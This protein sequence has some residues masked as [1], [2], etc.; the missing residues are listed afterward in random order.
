MAPKLIN[1]YT[2]NSSNGQRASIML[3]ESGLDYAA[4]KVDMSLGA[5]KLP[6]ALQ[7]LPSSDVPAL[8][9]ETGPGEAVILF[10]SA[11]IAL[12]V[13][14]K[15]GKFVPKDSA[16]RARVIQWLVQSVADV[17][18]ASY[19]LYY[20]VGNMTFDMGHQAAGFFEQRLLRY[21]DT[22]D[23][24]LSETPYLGGELSVADFALYPAVAF[25]RRIIQKAG[26]LKHL[27]RWAE[28]LGER[29]G[30]R[31][32]MAIAGFPREPEWGERIQKAAS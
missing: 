14:E 26:G 20:L 32:G 1:L 9:D 6:E 12:H 23:R 19:T 13:A 8:V 3:E 18:A 4:H 11:A 28:V 22:C 27:N 17:A 25:R 21:L 7:N 2:T 31:K 5:K 29:D 16:A 24:Q 15:S 10:Q 30:V